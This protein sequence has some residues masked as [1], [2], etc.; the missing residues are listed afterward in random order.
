MAE[1]SR[2]VLCSSSG[3][4]GARAQKGGEQGEDEQKHQEEHEGR[5]HLG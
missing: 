2:F 5:N 4:A 1:A 3:R